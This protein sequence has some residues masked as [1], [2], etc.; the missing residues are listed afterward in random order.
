MN[1]ILVHGHSGLR[2]LVL[3]LIVVAIVNALISRG[4]N[5]YVKKDK[6]INL[7]AMIFCHV[8][9]LI[10]LILYFISPKVRFDAPMA[11][12]ATRFFTVEHILM[13]ILAIVLITIGRKR[14]EKFEV[15]KKKHTTILMSYTIALAIIF[16][17]IPWKFIYTFGV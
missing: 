6:M 15:P 16:Y 4:K 14:A 7:F 12:D 5:A 3:L 10:G 8:Q 2:Y 13:M 11:N 17:M 1:N 9:L